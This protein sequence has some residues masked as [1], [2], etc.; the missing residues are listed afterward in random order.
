M[1]ITRLEPVYKDYIW[2][3]N[4]LNE[5]YGKNSGLSITAESW[6]LA[7]HKD[8][9]CRI[10]DGEYAGKT[11]LEVLQD[12]PDALGVKAARFEFFPILIKLIDACNDLSVQVHPSDDYALKNE[13]QYGKTEM[14]YVVDA[15]EDAKLV[16]GLNREVS[17]DEF[18]AL[19][20]GPELMSVLNFVPVKKGDV[21]F[22]S[23]GVIHAIGKGL[24]I[25]E[26]QQN[27]NLTYR[28]YDY[29]RVDINGNK[30]PLHVEKAI[31]VAKLAPEPLKSETAITY[32]DSEVKVENLASCDYF[33]VDK[34]TLNGS[35]SLCPDG[36]FISITVV[37]GEG[38]V[39]S[40]KTPKGTTVFI[41]ADAGSVKIEGNMT[42][43]ASY[44]N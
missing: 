14:W 3:G 20:N 24:L 2:G 36:S 32:L 11:L 38:S 10:T 40:L 44:V 31:E 13:G 35:Y 19:A 4:K 21:F 12:H 30:R 29:D 39:G 23:S 17:K 1:D 22:I 7:C 9:M 16:Y 26:I 42:A 25:C 28:V 6:E 18:A 37:D 8:G 15:V 27:S 34:I 41:P 43:L 33:I 5:E